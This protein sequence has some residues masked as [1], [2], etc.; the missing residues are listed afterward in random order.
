MHGMVD[1]FVHHPHDFCKVHLVWTPMAKNYM[2]RFVNWTLY[3][4]LQLD[5]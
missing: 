1:H 4:D 3:L 2:L 5:Y